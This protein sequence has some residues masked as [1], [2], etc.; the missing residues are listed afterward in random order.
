MILTLVVEEL[1][2][3]QNKSCTMELNDI[4]K[5]FGIGFTLIDFNWPNQTAR[6]PTDGTP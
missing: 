2:N 5:Y 1:L 3:T 6:T 4:E